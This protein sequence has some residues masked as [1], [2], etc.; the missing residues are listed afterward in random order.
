VPPRATPHLVP[1]RF[2]L[3]LCCYCEPF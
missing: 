1:A 2:D 3:C